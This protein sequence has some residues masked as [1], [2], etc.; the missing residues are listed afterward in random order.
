MDKKKYYKVVKRNGDS[1]I[2]S[3]KYRLHYEVGKKIIP[4]IGRI[5]ICGNI[6]EAKSF[7][8]EGIDEIYE[9]TCEDVRVEPVVP[10]PDLNNSEMEDEVIENFWIEGK[11]RTAISKNKLTAKSITLTKKVE[12]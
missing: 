11:L 6:H 7:A 4:K 3:R 8:T 12:G 1:C 5:F 9:C 10:A 2:V